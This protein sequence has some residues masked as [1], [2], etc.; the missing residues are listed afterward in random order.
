MPEDE[1]GTVTAPVADKAQ[2][3]E[4]VTKRIEDLE[5]NLA[6]QASAYERRIGGLLNANGQREEA[7]K[8]V[9][10][11]LG[12]KVEELSRWQEDVTIQTMEPE[13]QAAFRSRQVDQKVKE[14]EDQMAA[15]DEEVVQAKAIEAER[16]QEWQRALQLGVPTEQIDYSTPTTIRASITKWEGSHQSTE[17][18]EIRTELANLKSQQEK[19]T[20]K[21]D[22][23]ART[24]DGSALVPDAS[25]TGEASSTDEPLNLP[26]ELQEDYDF[27]MAQG[28]LPTN[29]RKSG[30]IVVAQMRLARAGVLV[31]VT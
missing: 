20:L 13:Q 2:E 31:K 17:L 5:K 1:N 9:I 15:R 10:D 24:N 29:R 22:Q 14:L 8:A 3:N 21:A 11:K 18:A 27:L 19:G 12:S 16:T 23:S 7:D 6:E 30:E 4:A 25:G 28:D 26:A